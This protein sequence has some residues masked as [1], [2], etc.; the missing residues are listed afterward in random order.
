MGIDYS[1]T[2]NLFFFT[3]R[4]SYFVLSVL[5]PFLHHVIHVGRASSGLPTANLRTQLA[6]RERRSLN[7]ASKQKAYPKRYAFCFDVSTSLRKVIFLGHSK[8]TSVLLPTN[9]VLYKKVDKFQDERL[10]IKKK[11]LDNSPNPQI[12]DHSKVQLPSIIWFS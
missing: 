10:T 4:T 12:V 3:T 9:F 7:Y 8:K 11:D 2:H 6:L 1:L 5:Q